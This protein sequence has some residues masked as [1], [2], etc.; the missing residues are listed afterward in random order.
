M[1]P[2]E[3]V[4]MLIG[5]IAAIALVVLMIGLKNTRDEDD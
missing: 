5:W 3:A 4:G 1:T 2:A